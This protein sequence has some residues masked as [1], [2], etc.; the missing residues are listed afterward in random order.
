ML[1]VNVTHLYLCVFCRMF[2]QSINHRFTFSFVITEPNSTLMAQWWTLCPHP[3]I[4]R[5]VGT[6]V[7]LTAGLQIPAGHSCRSVHLHLWVSLPEAEM[8]CSKNNH[9]QGREP[10]KAFRLAQDW[11]AWPFSPLFSSSLSWEERILRSC[12]EQLEKVRDSQDTAGVSSSHLGMTHWLVHSSLRHTPFCIC[13]CFKC[14]LKQTNCLIAATFCVCLTGE[15][16]RCIF[17]FQL[18]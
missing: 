11:L 14:E 13:C 18:L 5:S 6:L 9:P 12:W 10:P 7:S 3:H 1:Q 16:N 2:F 15:F 17:L 4:P 8:H